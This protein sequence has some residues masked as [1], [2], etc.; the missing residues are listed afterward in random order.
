MAQAY[1]TGKTCARSGAGCSSMAVS[2]KILVAVWVLGLDSAGAVYM[3][4]ARDSAKAPGYDKIVGTMKGLVD[5][6]LHKYE[7]EE[8]S[9][10]EASDAMAK[11]IDNAA[12]AEAKTRA[13]DEKAKMKVEHENTLKDLASFIRTMDDTIKAM[14][15]PD[16][17]WKD[18]FP[19]EKKKIEAIYTAYPALLQEKG[20]A[21]IRL[22]ASRNSLL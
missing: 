22:R 4:G 12:D 11:V 18:D 6:Y 9:F 1:S 17:D 7:D 13:V 8:T 5:G 14:A 19:E 15:P 16:T 2:M 3:Q 20:G 10:S 21:P